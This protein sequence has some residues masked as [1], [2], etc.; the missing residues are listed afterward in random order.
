MYRFDRHPI[1]TGI[2]V[3]M[4]VT[5]TMSLEHLLF[6][7]GST[8]YIWMGVYFEERSLQRQWGQQ[9]EDYRQRVGTIVPTFTSRLSTPAMTPSTAATGTR[10]SS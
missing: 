2:L 1:M 6:A 5:P 9:Y 7:A 8:I 4:W 3:G 10:E